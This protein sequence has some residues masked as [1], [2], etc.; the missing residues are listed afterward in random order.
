MVECSNLAALTG[1]EMVLGIV[2]LLELRPG[3]I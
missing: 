2:E 3:N 1:C